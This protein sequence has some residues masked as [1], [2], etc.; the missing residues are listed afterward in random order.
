MKAGIMQPYFF[1]YIGYWQLMNAVDQYVIYDDV[2]YINRGWVNRNRIL[3]N[4]QPHY[5]N[6]QMIGASQ[7]KLINEI[8]INKEDA[9]ISK[10]LR[11]IENA[12]KKAPYYTDVQPLIEQVLRNKEEFL[13][14]VIAASF[15]VLCRYLDIHTELI[16]SSDLEKDNTLK[17]Q[18]KILAICKFLGATEYY[19]A[20]GG[21]EL[22]SFSE[23]KKQGIKLRFLK[24]DE[25]SYVQFDNEFCADLSIIDVMMF[26]SKE[27]VK[28]LLN[29]YTLVCE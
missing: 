3:L 10:N 20:V 22:Y 1:P 24:S 11:L 29:A 28:E 4:G 27:R 23:F 25:I 6:V 21:Q 16:L 19:N 7:C 12:Y 13:S 17:G 26:N 5:F 14:E 18:D 2:N 8:L 15:S 9:V